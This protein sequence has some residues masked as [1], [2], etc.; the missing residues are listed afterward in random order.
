MGAALALYKWGF[1][2]SPKW[3]GL[4]LLLWFG[5]GIF[6]VWVF[7]GWD[8]ITA[9]YVMTQTVTTIG[10]GDIVVNQVG[11][12]LEIFFS[13]YV[14]LTVLLAATILT[15]ALSGLFEGAAGGLGR[16]LQTMEGLDQQGKSEAGAGGVLKGKL[17]HWNT[18]LA[19]FGAVGVFVLF[20]TVFYGW[21][22]ACSCSYGVTA[23]D[24]CLEGPRCPETGGAVKS[25]L[26]AFYMSVI[27]LTTVGFGDHSP[28]T[29][30]GRLIGVPWMLLGVAA[31]ASFIGT[32]GDALRSHQREERILSRISREI[33]DK[34]D[35]SKDG[36]LSRNEF[37]VYALMKF[38]IVKE[39]DL[40]QIDSLFDII[41]VDGSKMVTLEEIESH[42]DN[43]K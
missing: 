27:T 9:A 8:L 7:E 26:N 31:T 19:H 36:K 14:F 6:M 34:I 38:E 24:G 17:R 28:K 12:S 32:F 1:P 21:Y 4:F 18:P 37:R 42:F 35:T 20:G 39:A 40:Q 43:N 3:K 29:Q 11:D 13:V 10:Y 41:D 23:V 30:V 15:D 22:E 33:F 5:V 25:Y 2:M 16:K